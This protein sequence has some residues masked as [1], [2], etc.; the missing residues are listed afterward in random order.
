MQSFKLT[1]TVIGLDVGSRSVKMVELKDTVSGVQLLNFKL[2]ELPLTSGK[3]NPDYDPVAN[4]VSAIKE[5]LKDFDTKM[6]KVF[7]VVGGPRVSVRR[8]VMPPMPKREMIDAVKWEAK[9]HIPFPVE[10]AIIDYQIIGDVV[11]QGVKKYDLLV[12]AAERSLIEEHLSLLKNAGIRVT[13]VTAAP[14]SLWNLVKKGGLKLPE[15]K[16]VALLNIGGD[17]TDINIFKGGGLQFTR[18][19]LIAGMNITRAMTGILVSDYGQIELDIHQAEELKK[20][21]GIPTDTESQMIDDKISSTQILALLRPII[22]RMVSEIKRSFAYHREESRG[23]R[24]E[25]V[26]LVGGCSKL[27]GFAE[28]LSKGLGMN[29]EVGDP[30]VS[31]DVQVDKEGASDVASRLAVVMGTALGGTKGI[32]LI[33]LEIRT[34]AQ[35]FLRRLSLEV[36]GTI[37][38]FFMLFNYIFMYSQVT[39]YNKRIKSSNIELATLRAEVERAA[40]LDTMRKNIA[41]RNSLIKELTD[42]GFDWVNILKEMSNIIPPDVILTSISLEEDETEFEDIGYYDETGEEGEIQEPQISGTL[43]IIGKILPRAAKTGQLATATL[44]KFTG[45]LEWSDYFSDIEL[46]SAVKD[47]GQ[48]MG[49]EVTCQIEE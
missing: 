11:E 42:K 7:S 2:V 3:E 36:V 35:R 21:W 24:V 34:Q 26:I 39:N 28:L 44:A 30:L 33:P 14:L 46:I 15:D 29:V 49:F 5:S 45:N 25:H 23:Q 37:A 18:Q 16:I 47:E 48:G 10:D 13:A 1:Q 19:V 12:V 8:V 40:D 32:N 6:V 20:K 41:R 17:V 22:D 27:K 38:A 31:V 4:K 43:K 9:N